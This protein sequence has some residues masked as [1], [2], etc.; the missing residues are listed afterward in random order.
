M[1]CVRAGVSLV[2]QV[3]LLGSCFFCLCYFLL[4]G[5]TLFLPWAG[6]SAPGALGPPACDNV[7]AET[8]NACSL[9]K[10]YLGLLDR[11]SLSL[12]RD[13]LRLLS[14]P[15]RSSFSSK[16]RSLSFSLELERRLGERLRLSLL[17]MIVMR[18]EFFDKQRTCHFVC[19]SRG[20]KS[21]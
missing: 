20:K 19:L 21:H 7:R 10:P 14:A 18:P 13:L 4:F 11:R 1:T 12:L 6:T 15:S 2:R 16:E 17:P 5:W 8:I 9:Q 3:H